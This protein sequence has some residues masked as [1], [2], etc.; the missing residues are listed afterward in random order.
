MAAVLARVGGPNTPPAGAVATVV[1]ALFQGLVRQR[2]ID[3]A[4]VPGE[5]LGEALR[6]LFAGIAAATP[7]G[8]IP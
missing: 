6:W 3:P 7:A 2:R 8:G 4:S 5:L 1:L